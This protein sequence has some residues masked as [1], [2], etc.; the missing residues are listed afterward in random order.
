MATRDGGCRLVRVTAPARLHM[1]F[2]DFEGGLGR[3]FGSLG[4][5][6]EDMATGGGRRTAARGRGEGPDAARAAGHLAALRS[7]W[8][9]AT[10]V[11]LN[12]EQ[13][14]PAHAGLGSGTQLG[15]AVGAALARL[16][17]IE[18]SPEIIAALLDRGARSGIGLGAF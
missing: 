11:E 16:F 5:A 17:G 9:L 2:L 10:P 4:L 7:A 1:G 8:G 14:I 6:V 12:I 3:R 18:A 13:A 15:L